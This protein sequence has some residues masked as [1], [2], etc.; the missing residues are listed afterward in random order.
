MTAAAA[1]L[2]LAALSLWVELRGPRS[3]A[4]LADFQV[5]HETSLDA[6]DSTARALL[7]G[8]SG[9]FVDVGGRAKKL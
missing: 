8:L 5:R 2:L 3:S 1:V 4:S 7:G 6:M 9:G